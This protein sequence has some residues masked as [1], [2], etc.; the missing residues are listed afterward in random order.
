[1]PDISFEIEFQSSVSNFDSI[2]MM[3]SVVK[4]FISIYSEDI[5]EI[6]KKGGF[7]VTE[8]LLNLNGSPVIENK[9]IPINPSS[10]GKE[11]RDREMREKKRKKYIDLNCIERLR[12]LLR[13][14]DYSSIILD[15]GNLSVY[16]QIFRDLEPDYIP[17]VPELRPGINESQNNFFVRE[18]D[19]YVHKST[20]IIIRYSDQRI[21]SSFY[22]ALDTGISARR[23]TGSGVMKVI[24][25]SQY[26]RGV[27]DGEGLYLLISPFIPGPGDLERINFSR[28]FYRIST[29]SGRDSNGASYDIYRYIEP[30][31]LLYL[32]N[33]PEGTVIAERNQLF[34]FK[35]FFVH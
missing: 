23:S 17:V 19:R 27:F 20:S 29:F 3:R 25:R 6:A 16:R 13:K 18:Y 4:N 14:S 12:E 21:L 34:I 33:E 32:K 15:D 1:M 28:S 30:G 5:I 26:N 2:K 9:F 24:R 35:G 31:A 7:V 10:L 8:P 11:T 22:A